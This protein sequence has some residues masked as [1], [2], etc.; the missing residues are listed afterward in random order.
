M[1]LQ[2]SG[3]ITLDDI[4]VEAGGSTGTLCSINDTDILALIS[5]NTAPHEFSEWYGAS[6][7]PAPVDYIDT[8]DWDTTSGSFT[9]VEISSGAGRSY[10]RLTIKR[11]GTW[12]ITGSQGTE[13][14]GDWHTSKS[15]TCGDDYNCYWYIG[16][17]DSSYIPDGC[18]TAS[19][20]PDTTCNTS[21]TNGALSTDRYFEIED[22]TFENGNSYWIRVFMYI[23]D[24]DMDFSG[25]GRTMTME[26]LWHDTT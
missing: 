13:E 12:I 9:N 7:G 1:A 14:S 15:S 4:H 5:P 10:M 17:P 18:W 25:Y 24:A 16:S 11:D 3:P 22:D 2:T 19:N 8:S 23:R 21:Y 20:H 6:S 26:T